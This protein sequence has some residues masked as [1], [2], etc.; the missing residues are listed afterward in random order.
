MKRT[1]TAALT[2]LT[3]VILAG[4]GIAVAVGSGQSAA[5]PTHRPTVTV[6]TVP[7]AG[8]H[9][10]ET[11]RQHTTAR[12]TVRETTHHAT[13]QARTQQQTTTRARTATRTTECAPDSTDHHAATTTRSRTTPQSQPTTPVHHDG[14]A[15]E[16][17]TDH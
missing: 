17:G 14:D 1:A 4:T 13:V 7:A 12:A 9:A 3:A 2:G 5:Q 16:H 15:H 6:S 8:L 11:E 10:Q